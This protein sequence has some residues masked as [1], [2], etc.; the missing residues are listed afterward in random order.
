MCVDLWWVEYKYQRICRYLCNSDAIQPIP[1]PSHVLEP[2][3][4]RRNTMASTR[5]IL[6]QNATILA[7]RGA[8]DDHIVPL[9]NHSLLIEGN[10]IS[11]IAPQIEAPSASTEVIDCTSKIISP[12]FIDTHHHVWQTQVKGRHADHTLVEYMVPGGLI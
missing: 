12:G 7:P 11:R 3:D 4:L 1:V 5:S 10:K 9:K 2:N 8:G 6:L